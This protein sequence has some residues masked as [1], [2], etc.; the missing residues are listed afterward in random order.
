M[1]SL[2]HVCRS[3]KSTFSVTGL[4]CLGSWESEEG[5]LEPPGDV[6]LPRRGCR[7]LGGWTGGTRRLSHTE[8]D[9]KSIP[10]TKTVCLNECMQKLVRSEFSV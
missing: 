2:V 6:G 5:A 9:G 8:R 4:H 1:L 3:P 10:D 7:C